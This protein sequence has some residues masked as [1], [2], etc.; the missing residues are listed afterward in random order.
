MK[1][2]AS[3]QL[4]KDQVLQSEVSESDSAILWPLT[5]VLKQFP[6]SRSLWLAG[7]RDGKYPQPIRLSKR[8]VAWRPEDIHDLVTNLALQQGLTSIHHNLISFNEKLKKPSLGLQ[9][10]ERLK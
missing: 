5:Q 10:N 9:R 2:L 1:Q 3:N 8:R 6:V 4:T 7:V